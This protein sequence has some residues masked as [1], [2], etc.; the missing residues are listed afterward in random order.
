MTEMP[1]P[2]VGELESMLKLAGIP[3]AAAEAATIVDAA[4]QQ[5]REP[6]MAAHARALA[7][8]RAAGTPLA[9]VVG[10]VRFLGVDVLIA[11]GALIPREETELLGRAALGILAQHPASSLRVVDMCCGSGN[12]ACAIAAGDHRVQMWA[13]DLT[14]GSVAIARANVE[15]LHLGDRVTVLQGDL[16]GPLANLGLEGSIDVIVCNPPYIS[17]GKLGKDRASLLQH[18]PR[19]AFD[20]GPYGVSIFQRVVRDALGFLKHGGTL[21]FEIGAGQDR[22]VLAL[23]ARARDYEAVD[24]VADATG[25]VRVVS[26]RK[27]V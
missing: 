2:L 4:S 11:P 8:R 15:H 20:G 13:S 18:E 27:K 5:A 25:V 24:T 16:F 6:D 7:V 21:L 14:E 9:Y 10:R 1:E 19:E 22:Q 23:L 17:T 3:E 26:A 12:L